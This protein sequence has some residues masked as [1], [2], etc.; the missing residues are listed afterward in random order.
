M[1]NLSEQERLDFIQIAEE[2]FND[3]CTIRQWTGTTK[4]EL[5][6]R[7][8]VFTLIEHVPCGFGPPGKPFER[9]VDQATVLQ[10]DALLRVS[11]DQDLSVKDEVIVRGRTYKVDGVIDGITVRIAPLRSTATAEE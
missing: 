2:T 1:P 6:Q 8:D 9:E 7:H 10:A 4:D 11:L 3:E 5:N